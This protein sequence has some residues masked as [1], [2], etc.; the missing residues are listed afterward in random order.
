MDGA[1]QKDIDPETIR[2]ALHQ[3]EVRLRSKSSYEKRRYANDPEYRAQKNARKVAW[4]TE[5]CLT[6][7]E[8]AARL[9]QYNK[10]WYARQR[11]NTQTEA[12]T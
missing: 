9:K 10:E 1:V 11:S 7:P 8:Y 2:T 3:R 4:T 5:K 6:D 12:T